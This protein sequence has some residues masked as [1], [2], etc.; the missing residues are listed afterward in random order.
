MMKYDK[1]TYNFLHLWFVTPMLHHLPILESS[2]PDCKSWR[3]VIHA[4]AHP[5]LEIWIFFRGTH[6]ALKLYSLSCGASRAPQLS[7]WIEKYMHYIHTYVWIYMHISNDIECSLIDPLLP[8]LEASLNNSFRHIH[9]ATTRPCDARATTGPC[10]T[11]AIGFHLS[12]CSL[13]RRDWHPGQS[14]LNC[15][16]FGSFLPF[17][18]STGRKNISLFATCNFSNSNELTSKTISPPPKASL[19]SSPAWDASRRWSTGQTFVLSRVFQKRYEKNPFIMDQFGEQG[20]KYCYL[21]QSH[22]WDDEYVVRILY[23][24]VQDCVPV[25]KKK[26]VQQL[27]LVTRCPFWVKYS[28]NFVNPPPVFTNPPKWV[29]HGQSLPTG[30]NGKKNLSFQTHQSLQRPAMWCHTF[31]VLPCYLV[32]FLRAIGVRLQILQQRAENALQLR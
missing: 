11:R 2:D 20:K 19:P 32:I 25:A 24:M 10:S 1:I 6:T 23:I 12:N 4:R 8:T 9:L 13:P 21:G 27:Q 26:W 28:K 30:P 15:R 22:A 18:C 14:Q 17:C 16:V 31:P 29:L 3:P 7:I 5:V